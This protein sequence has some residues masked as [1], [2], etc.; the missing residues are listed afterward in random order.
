MNKKGQFEISFGFIFAIIVIAAIIAVA[1][2][3]IIHF[4]SLQKCSQTGL[5]YSDLQAEIDKAWGGSIS[6][7][8]FSGTLPS[9]LDSICFGYLNS[10]AV[11]GSSTAQIELRKFQN[12]GKNAF[13]YPNTKACS[14]S[15]SMYK[16]EHVRIDKFFCVPVS[17]GK[18]TVKVLKNETDSLVTL[19][20]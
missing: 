3:V 12:L 9:N 11:K 13:L 10:T 5:Y 18:A 7:N 8:Q 17:S 16:F 19:A 4:L 20:P 6:S 1:V 14:A 2:Y 15:L